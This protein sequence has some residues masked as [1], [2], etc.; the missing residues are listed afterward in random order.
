MQFVFN[1]AKLNSLRHD[2]PTCNLL[3]SLVHIGALDATDFKAI[4]GLDLVDKVTKS[5]SEAP[6][7]SAAE[8]D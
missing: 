4:T 8:K 2:R 1:K 7:D 5:N 6:D 3:A